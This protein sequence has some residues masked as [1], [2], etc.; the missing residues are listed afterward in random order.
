MTSR[1]STRRFLPI[2]PTNVRPNAKTDSSAEHG[3]YSWFTH[4]VVVAVTIVVVV[5]VAVTNVGV[6]VVVAAVGVFVSV[7]VAH[8][9]LLEV[10]VAV[11]HV[12]V[13]SVAL[14]VD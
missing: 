5:V 6:F 2:R 12:D 10:D 11:K 8:N 13:V 9:V 7:S 3:W 4:V 1:I 14:N